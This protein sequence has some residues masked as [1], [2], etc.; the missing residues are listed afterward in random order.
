M[1]IMPMLENP[2]RIKITGKCN[3]KCFFC[4][5]EGGMDIDTIVFSE[6]LKKIIETLSSEFGMCSAA[7]TG[8]EPLLYRDMK[9]LSSSIMKCKGMKKLSLTTNGTIY[10]DKAY[11]ELLKK[12][13]LYKV[14]ISMPDILTGNVLRFDPIMR[15]IS[16]DNIFLN[17]RMIIQILNSLGIEVKINVA[18]VNDELYTM[19]VLNQ[20]L[21]LQDLSFEIVLLPNITSEETFLYSQMVIKNIISLMKLKLIA[22]RTRCY[23]SNSIFLYQNEDGKKISIKTTKLINTSN[24]LQTM[25]EKCSIKDECQEGF[26]GLRLEQI[27]GEYFIRLC[28]HKNSDET[29]M[30]FD[31][32]LKS[33]MFE[34]LKEKWGH[35]SY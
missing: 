31:K 32:F 18:V 19:S 5:Q 12:N 20:L 17:Q 3:R 22:T 25:C 9:T 27:K 28:I 15:N 14:N 7:F 2:I 24:R 11:W 13:G 6:N 34:E 26:Y 35:S 23:T 10:K 16:S 30:L 33:P 1:E 8:G 21:N 4:H 29:L